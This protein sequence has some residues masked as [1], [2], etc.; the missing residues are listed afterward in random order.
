M[1]VATF[2]TIHG[3]HPVFPPVPCYVTVG[4]TPIAVQRAAGTYFA[5]IDQ[6]PAYS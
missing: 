6:V 5:A 1:H 4:I 3:T 2:L